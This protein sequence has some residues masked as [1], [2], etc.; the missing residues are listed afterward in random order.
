M[1]PID[2]RTFLVNGTLTSGAVVAAGALGALGARRAAGACRRQQPC[3]KEGA[4]PVSAYPL[5]LV[6]WSTVRHRQ[7]QGDGAT[8]AGVGTSATIMSC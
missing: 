7:H 5:L 8:P 6:H 3:H 2:R 1:N 4:R